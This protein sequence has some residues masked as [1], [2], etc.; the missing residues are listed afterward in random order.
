MAVTDA[1][2]GLGLGALLLDAASAEART[3]G[4]PEL[5]LHTNVAMTENL[6]WYPRRGFEETHRETQD[7]YDRV[8]YRRP[9]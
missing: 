8:F 7:G 2:R 3:L 1:A 4:L 5:R 9:V 6:T